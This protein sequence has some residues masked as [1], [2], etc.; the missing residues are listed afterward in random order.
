LVFYPS[1][2]FTWTE[3][4]VFEVVRVI[5]DRSSRSPRMNR[6][7]RPVRI[8]REATGSQSTQMRVQVQATGDLMWRLWYW[9]IEPFVL[10]NDPLVPGFLSQLHFLPVVTVTSTHR[11]LSEL[12]SATFFHRLAVN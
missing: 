3:V 9:S 1:Q 11:P 8:D 5:S 6:F 10:V 7:P 4:H 12:F 2:L